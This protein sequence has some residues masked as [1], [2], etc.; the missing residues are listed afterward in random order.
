MDASEA[1]GRHEADADGAAD[2]ERRAR[3]RRADL[4]A[5]GGGR[6][7]AR[8]DLP[9]LRGEPLEFGGWDADPDQAVEDADGRGHRPLFLHTRVNLRPNLH[10][11]P[12]W[13]AVRDERSLERDDRAALA[14]RF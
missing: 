13:E 3:G 12:G 6:E 11:H 7:V 2:G 8:P 9:R 10:P 14:Q 4:A 5:D 1:A